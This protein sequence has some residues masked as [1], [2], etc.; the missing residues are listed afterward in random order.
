[1]THDQHV[2][3]GARDLARLAQDQLARTRVLVRTRRE[4]VRCRARLHAGEV[5]EAVFGARQHLGRHHQHIVGA[6]F[7]LRLRERRAEQ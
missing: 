3:R 5:H 7:D 4:L 1:V 6:R 2:G